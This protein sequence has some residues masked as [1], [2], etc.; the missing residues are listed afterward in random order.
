MG[1]KGYRGAFRFSAED[2]LLHGPILAIEDVVIFEGADIR[3]L[4]RAFHDA[5][6]DYSALC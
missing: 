2:R 3:E 6:D 5:V 4:E 1:Y